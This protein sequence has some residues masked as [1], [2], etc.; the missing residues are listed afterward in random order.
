[1]TTELQMLLMAGGVVAVLYI[2]NVLVSR[3]LGMPL[4]CH[5]GLHRWRTEVV[6]H[7]RDTR[8]IIK[9]AGCAAL[10]DET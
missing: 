8:H 10:K 5:L 1:M 9:C 4:F 7:G 6:G 2:G 3:A